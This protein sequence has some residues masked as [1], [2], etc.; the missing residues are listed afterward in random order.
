M[1]AGGLSHAGKALGGVNFGASPQGEPK[2]SIYVL[3]ASKELAPLV[4]APGCQVSD[5]RVSQGG[6]ADARCQAK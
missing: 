1:A 4:R 3:D 5:R 6:K 2:C